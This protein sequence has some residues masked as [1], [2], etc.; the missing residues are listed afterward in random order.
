MSRTIAIA[1]NI[2]LDIEVNGEHWKIA[3]TSLV[4]IYS[5]EF[6]LAKEFIL[7]TFD[8]QKMKSTFRVHGAQLFEKRAKIDP[9]AF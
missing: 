3:E 2:V 5:M 6:D 4:G 1:V 8:G 7:I 9:T